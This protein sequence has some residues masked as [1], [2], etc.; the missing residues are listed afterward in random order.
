MATLGFRLRL[1]VLLVLLFAS[2]EGRVQQNPSHL[3]FIF[4]NLV[5]LLETTG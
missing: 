4:H 5:Q 2:A 3:Q 1:S